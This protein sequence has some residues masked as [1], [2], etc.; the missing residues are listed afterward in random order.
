MNGRFILAAFQLPGFDVLPV[1]W[2][3]CLLAMISSSSF[4]APSHHLFMIPDTQS[5]DQEHSRRCIKQ[6]RREKPCDIAGAKGPGMM[7]FP[8]K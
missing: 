3:I 2:F 1:G 4:I 6:K 5:A 7:Y 8:T